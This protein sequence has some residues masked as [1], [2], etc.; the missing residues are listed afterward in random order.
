MNKILKNIF[1]PLIFVALLFL[2]AGS[3]SVI[4]SENIIHSINMEVMLNED[5]SATIKAL[6]DMSQYEGTEIYIPMGSNKVSQVIDFTVSEEGKVYENLGNDWDTDGSLEE[7]RFKNGINESSDQQELCWGIGS[8]GKHLYQLEYTI[9]NFVRKTSDGKYMIFWKFFNDSMNIPI[10]KM[11]VHINAFSKMPAADLRVWGFGFEGETEILDEGTI[12]AQSHGKI[13][14]FTVLSILPDGLFQTEVEMDESSED[15]IDKA[16]DGSDYAEVDGDGFSLS[17]LLAFLAIIPPFIAVATAIATIISS[18][19]TSHSYRSEL[20]IKDYDGQYWRDVPLEG[21]IHI[22]ILPLDGLHF[23]DEDS[24]MTAYFLKWIKEGYLVVVDDKKVRGFF[25]KKSKKNKKA[26]QI[27]ADKFHKENKMASDIELDL[28]SMIEEASVDGI[29]EAK[30]FTEWATDE[31][32]RLEEWQDDIYASSESV[33]CEEGYYR[34][35]KKRSWLKLNQL[36]P[37]SKGKLLEENIIKFRNYLLDFSLLNERGAINVH[38]WDDLLI[39]AAMLGIADEVYEEFSKLYPEYIVQTNMTPEA[40][41]WSHYYPSHAISA[42][43]NASA[44][45]SSG[46]GGSTSF[47]GGGSSFGGGSGGGFR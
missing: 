40:I 10:D 9:T 5:G 11:T 23:G 16:K 21:D 44:S 1:A 32:D 47:T 41:Y 19:N 24:I 18:G 28:F 42:A 45:S 14:Y 3:Q 46:Y 22:A 43:S 29:L 35:N 37:T 12:F 31:Y 13:N 39:W 8:Y 7:K 20:R 38:L 25:N 2:G 27:D 30:E 34:Y 26:L 15:I 36:E 4:A 33:L 17:D 6:W